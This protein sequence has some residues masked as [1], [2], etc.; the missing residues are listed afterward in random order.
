VNAIV[1]SPSIRSRYTVAVAHALQSE[2][3]TVT[4]IVVRRMLH[5]GRI[6][7][8]WRS[9]R[10]RLLTKIV[11]RGLQLDSDALAESSVSIATLIAEANLPPDVRAFCTAR[12]V[13]LLPCDDFGDPAVLDALERE[14]PDAVFFTGGGMIRKPVLDRAGAGVVNCHMG[15]LPKYRGMDVIEWPVLLGEGCEVTCHFMDEGLDTGPI[16]LSRP[17]PFVRGDTF[18][19][20]RVRAEVEMVEAM[21]AVA[22]GLR[23]GTLQPRPQAFEE[24]RQYFAMH[25]RLLAEAREQLARMSNE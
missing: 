4:S 15:P 5:L 21:R 18:A 1:L 14:K 12:G 3:F 22:H 25:P 2:G 6:R 23:Q 20:I 11:R 8:E 16:L 13:R 17:V 7:S 9:A 24:G 19:R 10:S